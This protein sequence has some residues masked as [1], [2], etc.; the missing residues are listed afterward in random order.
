MFSGISKLFSGTEDAEK[1]LMMEV[2]KAQMI[3]YW[4][5]IV[6]MPSIK[7]LLCVNGL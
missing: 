7:V 1:V 4:L 6:Y 3:Y 2:V 5:D